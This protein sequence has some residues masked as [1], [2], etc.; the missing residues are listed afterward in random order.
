M[1]RLVVPLIVVALVTGVELGARKVENRVPEPLTW[2]T[3]FSQDKAAQLQQWGERLDVV[4]TGSSVAEANFDP[5]LFSSLSPQL[6]SGYNAGLPS[7][8]PMVWRQF[9]LDTVY[10][11]H[12]PA[13]LVIGVDI[14]QF[15][16]NKPGSNG[17]LSRYLNSRGRLETIGGDDIWDDGEGWLESHFAIF[18]IRARL[19]EPDKVVAWIWNVGDIGD[20]RNTN[21]SPEGRYQSNDN[22]TYEVSE[23]RLAELRDGAFLDLSFG[24]KETRALRGIIEDAR[25][26][27]T[28][29]V[30]V[31]MPTMAEDLVRALP[32]GAD[33]Q[34]R[35]TEVLAGV[36]A[37]YGIPFLRF[38]EI[39]N[40]SVYYS[41]VYHMNWTGVEKITTLLAQRIA[42]LDLDLSPGVCRPG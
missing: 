16:D 18:R 36:A 39:D 25:A 30:L 6:T 2:D 23:E 11:D 24:G 8:T 5:A 13:L 21:L 19:R 10:S 28:A 27:E 9:L 12:C 26:R 7:M 20:W 22:R 29:V 3:Q 1:R 38:P 33:D 14:R 34:R 31:E 4:F 15:N 42:E 17:Q 32:D 40:E 41:D 37:D 35:F